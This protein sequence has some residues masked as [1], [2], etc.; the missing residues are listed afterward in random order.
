MSRTLALLVAVA[1]AAT[2][3]SAVVATHAS[4]SGQTPA[5]A[6]A[7]RPAPQPQADGGLTPAPNRRADEGRGPFKTLV[8]RGVTLIDG[9]GA[10]PQGP[11]DIVVSGNRI[12]SVRSAGTPGLAMRTN[13]APQ[14][15]DLEVD[16]TGHV[17]H[18]GIRR[19]AR[20]R[21][22]RSEERG[23]GVRLQALA[24]ARRDDRPRRAARQQQRDG[25]RQAAQ[26]EERDR[27]AAH[28]QLPASGAAA[29]TRAA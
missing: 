25:R 28:L 3:G 12:T 1:C 23:S 9:S 10:P 7:A 22:R 15:A 26:R 11:V 29:G 20:A 17:P 27:R 24:R 19:H 16:A 8:I 18:A 6:P 4:S 13:R 2:S 21:R 5:P 14:N